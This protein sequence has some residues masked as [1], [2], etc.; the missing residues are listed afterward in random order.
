MPI[1]EH[2]VEPVQALSL[3]VLLKAFSNGCAALTGVEAISN[4]VQVFQPPDR[5][6]RPRP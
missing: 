6:T 1:P 4:S 2:A 3:I 5:A